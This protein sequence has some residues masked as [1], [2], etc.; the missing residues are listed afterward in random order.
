ML[1]KFIPK[2]LFG[3]FVLIIVIPTIIVQIIAVYIFYYTHIDRNSK[4]MARS[5]IGEIKIY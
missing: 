3:R 4:Y 5:L 1:K 2:T